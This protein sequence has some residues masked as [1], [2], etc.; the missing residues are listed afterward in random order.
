MKAATWM[1]G[2]M[3]VP[4]AEIQEIGEACRG[5]QGNEGKKKKKMEVA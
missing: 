3:D 4:V 1:E 5:R 2:E